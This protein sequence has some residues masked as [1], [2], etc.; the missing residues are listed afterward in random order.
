M[1]KEQISARIDDKLLDALNKLIGDNMAYYTL[2]SKLEALIKMNTLNYNKALKSLVNK[3]T[4]LEAC[5]MA[6]AFNGGSAQLDIIPTKD[7]LY[8]KVSEFY[9]Y[10]SMGFISNEPV[11]VK[12]LLDKLDDLDDYQALA[13]ICS[14]Q[15][16]WSADKD[17]QDLVMV[18]KE[19]DK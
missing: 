15:E 9:T 14:L 3:F 8:N 6:Q 12:A 18:Q 17:I 4:Y 13:V 11:D 1:T 19:E 2:T 10:G 5:Y 16:F 7:F